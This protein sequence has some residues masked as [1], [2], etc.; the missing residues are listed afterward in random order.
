MH[1]LE[2][3]KKALTGNWKEAQEGIL[4]ERGKPDHYYYDCGCCGDDEEHYQN[5]SKCL[6]SIQAYVLANR[7]VAYSFRRDAGELANNLLNSRM[8][9]LSNLYMMVPYAFEHIPPTRPILQHLGDRFCGMKRKPEDIE[10][11]VEV[12]TKLP[13]AFTRKVVR[14][15]QE[16]VESSKTGNGIRRCYNAHTDSEEEQCGRLHMKRNDKTELGHFLKRP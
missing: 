8:F 11:L 12:E 4:F 2:Y 15:Y 14:R 16:L 3:F 1:H 5:P 7:L 6:P 9:T 10:K 13:V